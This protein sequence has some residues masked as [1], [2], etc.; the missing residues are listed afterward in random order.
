M[1][2]TSTACGQGTGVGVEGQAE[3]VLDLGGKAALVAVVE[4]HVEGGQAAQHGETDPP[5]G[6]DPDVHAF[7]VV[8]PLHAV[9]DVP[10]ALGD[11]VVGGQEVP[12]QGQD[13]H[14]GVLGHADAVAEGHLGHRDAPGDGRV[15][16]DVVRADAG[17]D[18]QLEIGGLGDALGGQVGRPERLGDDDVGVGQLLLEDRVGALLVGRDDQRVAGRLRGTRRSPSSP[19]THPSSWPGVKS[20]AS[21]VGSVWPS[22]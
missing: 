13:L 7:E 2:R 11:P 20:I 4:A 5:G 12:D 15:Q 6:E 9:G 3:L 10:A 14:D 1:D 18:G 8:G 16:V 22:G 19:D 21:G 17:G